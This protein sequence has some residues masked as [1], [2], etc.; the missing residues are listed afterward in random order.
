MKRFAHIASLTL[1]VV[2]GVITAIPFLLSWWVC[3]TYRSI[4]AGWAVSG[5]ESIEKKAAVRQLLGDT[6]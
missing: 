3:A 2:E 1:I 6:K 4:L 5:M